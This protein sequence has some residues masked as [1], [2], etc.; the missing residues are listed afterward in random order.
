MM[1]VPKMATQAMPATVNAQ[2]TPKPSPMGAEPPTSGIEPDKNQMAPGM[3]N[4]VPAQNPS[5]LTRQGTK[6][7]KPDMSKAKKP[8]RSIADL[9]ARKNA[10]MNKTPGSTTNGPGIP[11]QPK[12]LG[13][14]EPKTPTMSNKLPNGFKNG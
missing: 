8:V 5:L 10:M 9:I 3:G 4:P 13:I 1:K 2:Y 14:L 12:K 11:S 6:M 7:I